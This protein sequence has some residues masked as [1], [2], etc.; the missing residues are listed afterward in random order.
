VPGDAPS[1]ER[2]TEDAAGVLDSEDMSTTTFWPSAVPSAK[3]TS[4]RRPFSPLVF[5]SVPLESNSS[6]MPLVFSLAPV[7]A[8]PAPTSVMCIIQVSAASLDPV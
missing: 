1:A 3:V 8:P 7:Q 5:T 6:R 4:S 2:V